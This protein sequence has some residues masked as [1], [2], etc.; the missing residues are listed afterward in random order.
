MMKYLYIKIYITPKS[1]NMSVMLSTRP[2]SY[3]VIITNTEVVSE[4]PPC[5]GSEGR[6]FTMK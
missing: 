4:Y 5:F 6:Q 1:E 2:S 3:T